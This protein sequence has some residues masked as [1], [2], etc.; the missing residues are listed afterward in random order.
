MKV[1]ILVATHKQY[2]FPKNEIYIPIQV[3]SIL[4]QNDFGY[5]GDDSGE[6]ISHKNDSFSELSALYWAWKNEYFK[7]SDFC[8]LVHYRRYFEGT[9]SFGKFRILSEG[10]IMHYMSQYDVV[11][12]RKRKYYIET[13]RS[14]YDHAHYKKDLDTLEEVLREYFPEYMPAFIAVM[15]QKS[16]YLYNMFVMKSKYYDDYCLWLFTILFEVEK[17]V[18]IS[19]YD[20]YQKRIFGFLGERLFNVWLLHHKLKVK[21]I[22]VKNIEGENLI[23]KAVNMLKRKYIK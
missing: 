21:E 9:E 15:D 16:L 14:H 23:L 3:G 10:D 19:A 2:R 8:G 6:S 11:V 17:R 22:K 12:P 7:E 5:L 18:D 4:H 20:R 13:V 1:K